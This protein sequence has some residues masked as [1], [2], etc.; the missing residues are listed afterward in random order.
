MINVASRNIFVT[1]M[2]YDTPR[3]PGK[4]STQEQLPPNL[5][6]NL[7]A[8]GEFSGRLEA[9]EKAHMVPQQ[10]PFHE[11]LTKPDATAKSSEEVT[12]CSAVG[13]RRQSREDADTTFHEL[14]SQP[15]C[16]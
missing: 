14:K 12:V 10:F 6:T 3:E 16:L 9:D 11:A 15:Y 7:C 5:A 1:V 13:S 8:P 4:T 2:L